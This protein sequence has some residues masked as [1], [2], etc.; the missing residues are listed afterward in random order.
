MR[1]CLE[2]TDKILLFAVLKRW[3]F[4]LKP[5]FH[6]KINFLKR[7]SDPTE[8]P[9]SVDRPIFLFQAWF[10]HEMK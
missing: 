2:F 4:Q 10:H 8:P 9:P 3:L 6:V 5:M 1:L 7:I